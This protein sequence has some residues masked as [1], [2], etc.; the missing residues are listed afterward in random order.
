[1]YTNTIK[2]GKKTS[3]IIA[4]CDTLEL[5]ATKRFMSKIFSNLF[6]VSQKCYVR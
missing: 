3:Q 2:Q 1:M 4:R 6:T 5:F